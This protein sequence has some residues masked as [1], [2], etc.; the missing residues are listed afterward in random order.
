MSA[1]VPHHHNVYIVH[2]V[3][4][5]SRVSLWSCCGSHQTQAHSQSYHGTTTP[6]PAGEKSWT[7]TGLSSL[8][9][10]TLLGAGGLGGDPWHCHH[11]GVG[12]WLEA[13][14]TTAT[15]FSGGTMASLN[16]HHCSLRGRWE[17]SGT[18]RCWLSWP[19]CLAWKPYSGPQT[20]SVVEWDS[21]LACVLC[22]EPSLF[23][24]CWKLF[25]KALFIL[26][27]I[28]SSFSLIV[29]TE[30]QKLWCL[31]SLPFLLFI[32]FSRR[33]SLLGRT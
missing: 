26:Q 11:D 23:R 31:V 9:L 8:D 22:M 20:A 5:C 24:T 19:P 15:S 18:P 25:P 21:N 3:Y 27:G 29:S 4:C 30:M 2:N 7:Y 16:A 28:L 33:N 14:E 12:W 10:C 17:G 6:W 13:G 32:A 1:A